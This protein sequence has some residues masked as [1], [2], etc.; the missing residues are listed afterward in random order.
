MDR[1]DASVAK[2]RWYYPMPAWLVYGPVVATIALFACE[3]W[4]WFPV[5]YQKG[6]PVVSAV[7]VV[8][9]VFVIT[10]AWLLVALV[11]RR[12]VQFGLRTLLVLVTLS[13]VVC[14]WLAV[15]IKLAA[16]QAE[17]VTAVREKL[18]GVLFYDWQYEQAEQAARK[19]GCGLWMGMFGITSPPSLVP[20]EPEPLGK[21][22]GV[23]FFH[24]AEHLAMLNS[25]STDGLLGDLALLTGLKELHIRSDDVTDAGLLQIE[26]LK[27]LQLLVLAQTKVTADGVKKLQ[28]ALPHC[29]IVGR[30]G[31]K[32]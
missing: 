5:G 3:R 24:D 31:V 8:A 13:A 32:Q 29:C 21:L 19:N 7:A 11:F 15:R 20:P 18:G 4:R 14:S 6:W 28:Q 10:S 25:K 16:R 30:P 26:R 27:S 9:A 17:V 12:R 2:R 1:M 23:D 22:M